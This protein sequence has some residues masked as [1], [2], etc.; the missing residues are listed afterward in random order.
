MYNQ[1]LCEVLC[2]CCDGRSGS[3][4]QTGSGFFSAQCFL[5]KRIT[6]FGAF[7]ARDGTQ[8]DE[9]GTTIRVILQ[10][11]WCNDDLCP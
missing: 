9:C 6:P 7:A 10:K 3:E 11:G 8:I 4:Q 1:A 2:N 5:M